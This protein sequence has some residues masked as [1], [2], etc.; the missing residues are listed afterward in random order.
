MSDLQQVL[1]GG[2]LVEPTVC[3]AGL[4]G[5]T[6]I[7]TW[8]SQSRVPWGGFGNKLQTFFHDSFKHLSLW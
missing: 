6:S 2:V 5:V 8:E 4:P 7:E 3:T 1:L